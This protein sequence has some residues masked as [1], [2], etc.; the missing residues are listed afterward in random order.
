MTLEAGRAMVDRRRLTDR[1]N[2]A[3]AYQLLADLDPERWR[4]IDDEPSTVLERDLASKT[5]AGSGRAEGSLV[6]RCSGFREWEGVG[7]IT[8]VR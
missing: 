5:S 7:W 8:S 1:P 6:D 3:R 2:L 4:I